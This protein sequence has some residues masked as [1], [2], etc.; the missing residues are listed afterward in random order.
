M[1][2][3]EGDL[4][5]LSRSIRNTE[6]YIICNSKIRGTIEKKNSTNYMI[7]C[8]IPLLVLST[9]KNLFTDRETIVTIFS[10]VPRADV[11]KQKSTVAIGYVFTTNTVIS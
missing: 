11:P 5:Y 9:L 7:A 1:Y 3:L 6:Y 2:G 10:L 8:G 4:L